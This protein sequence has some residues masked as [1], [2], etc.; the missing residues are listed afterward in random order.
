[1]QVRKSEPA[2]S[3]ACSIE[4]GH[5][6]ISK[7]ASTPGL[8]TFLVRDPKDINSLRVH[9]TMRA[10]GCSFDS[11][12]R[13]WTCRFDALELAMRTL[14]A[15]MPADDRYHA[16]SWGSV[17]ISP[18][19][20]GGAV[21]RPKKVLDRGGMLISMDDIRADRSKKDDSWF[22]TPE[23][24]PEFLQQAG[25]RTEK[26]GRVLFE[27]HSGFDIAVNPD[28]SVA[29]EWYDTH[30]LVQTITVARTEVRIYTMDPARPEML[31][32]YTKG[33]AMLPRLRE[34]L[35]PGATWIQKFSGYLA[36][37]DEIA[38]LKDD[39]EDVFGLR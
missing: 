32:C 5:L 11:N 9:E 10:E 39:D 29:R 26:T 16:V 24:V 35:P 31:G 30:R 4:G 15:P 18:T 13:T 33:S 28:G 1:M 37:S 23:R 2:A 36:H 19:R 22:T 7:I 38:F 34:R 25:A 14:R 21:L 6:R 27:S 12:G 3:K 17:I 20:I 8:G